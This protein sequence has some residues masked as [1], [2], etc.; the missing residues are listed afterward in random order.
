M[1]SKPWEV[2]LDS[3]TAKQ[4]AKYYSAVEVLRKMRKG[5]TLTKASR[6]VGVSPTTVKKYVGSALVKTKRRIVPY[7][8]DSLLRRT[9]IYENGRLV[10]IQVRG[11]KKASRILA[12]RDSVERRIDNNKKNA[13][14]PFEGL[15]VTDFEGKK[16][17]LETDIAKLR[18]IL[19]THEEGIHPYGPGR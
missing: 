6:D 3:L 2:N 12:Y 9:N 1:T 13:L 7:K 18:S 14:A 19:E 11:N 16:H 8:E 15:T 5:E 4:E 10:S 17:R